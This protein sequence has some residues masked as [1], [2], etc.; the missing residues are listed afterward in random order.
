MN[1]QSQFMRFTS[2]I[3]INITNK[4]KKVNKYFVK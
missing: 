2:T 4:Q 1:Y 3:M